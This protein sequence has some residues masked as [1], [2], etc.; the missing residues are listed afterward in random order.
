ML[1]A[2]GDESPLFTALDQCVFEDYG[3]EHLGT[4]EAL[5]RAGADPNHGRLPRLPS[6][7]A[8]AISY[9]PDRKWLDG[10]G[11]LLRHG[12]VLRDDDSPHLLLRAA[13]TRQL[14]FFRLLVDHP[15]HLPGLLRRHAPGENFLRL[16][17]H[18]YAADTVPSMAWAARC[19]RTLHDAYGFAMPSPPRAYLREPYD[20]FLQVLYR[21][22]RLAIALQRRFI[23]YGLTHEATAHIEAHLRALGGPLLPLT[24]ARAVAEA[25]GL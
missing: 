1:L 20:A 4:L 21:R 8:F 17:L 13:Q 16:F 18:T 9:L 25:R 22:R 5:L 14:L 2:E 24:L 11:L 19:I 3:G 6:L 10:V 7:L 15:R 12:A 23:A